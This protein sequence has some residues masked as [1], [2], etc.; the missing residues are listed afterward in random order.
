MMNANGGDWLVTKPTL[1]VAGEAGWERALF[2]P[3]G[4]SRKGARGGSVVFESG[5]IH[6]NSSR[7]MDILYLVDELIGEIERRLI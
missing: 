5:A 4:G 3:V 2:E 6:V 7:N 1:F